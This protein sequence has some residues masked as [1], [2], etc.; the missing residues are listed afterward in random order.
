MMLRTLSDRARAEGAQALRKALDGILGGR[1]RSRRDFYVVRVSPSERDDAEESSIATP[2]SQ[3]ERAPVEPGVAQ[4]YGKADESAPLDLPG[5]DFEVTRAVDRIADA[6]ERLAGR[7]DAYHHER[8]EHL[9]AIEF[10]VREMVM[11]AIPAARPLVHGGVVEPD[12]IDLTRPE[13]IISE[14]YPLAVDTPVEVRSRFQDRW[15]CGFVI[16]QTVEDAG[17]TQYRLTRHAD[18]TPLPILFDARDV[19]A[20]TSTFD[21]TRATE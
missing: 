18:G 1:G 13:P 11:G 12:V 3:T 6:V 5:R 7:L 17:R 16:A 8:S 15:V 10:L 9:D 2:V 14:R 20:T 19:R 21:R 4:S